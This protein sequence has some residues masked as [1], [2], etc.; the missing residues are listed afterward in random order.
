MSD[1][2]SSKEDCQCQE[3]TSDSESLEVGCEEVGVVHHEDILLTSIEALCT[4]DTYSDVTLIVDGQKFPAH[5]VILAAQS[6]YFQALL[7]GDLKESSQSVIELKEVA[8]DPFKELLKYIY[9]G[10]LNLTALEGQVNIVKFV[11]EIL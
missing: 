3:K 4:S 7:F 2:E 6:R 11:Y 8:V 9:T 10:C 5:K 1:S